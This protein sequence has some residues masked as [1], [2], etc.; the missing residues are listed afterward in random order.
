MTPEEKYKKRQQWFRDRIGKTVYRNDIDCCERCKKVYEEGLV[1]SDQMHADY[2]NDME[3]ISHAED[4]PV[5]YFDTREE[6]LE[7]EKELKK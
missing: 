3:S 6:A 5:K 7:Y 4:R 2:L 1:I